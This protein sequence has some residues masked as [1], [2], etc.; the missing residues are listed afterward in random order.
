MR[1]FLASMAIVVAALLAA[2]TT[3]AHVLITDQT[4]ERGAILH[5]VPDDDPIA[6]KTAT[7]FF[8]TQHNLLD[9]TS[10]ATVSI[11]QEGS[12]QATQLATKIDGP[13]ITANFVF[14]RQGVYQLRYTI[15]SSAGSLVFEHTA[16]VS[17]GIAVGTLD[18][19]R[20]T[21]AEGV[22]FGCSALLA[23][24]GILAWNRRKD[25]ARQST[26]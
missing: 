7:L 8:D 1:Y 22:L 5:I 4:G 19:P 16:R 21:W 23:C 24:L 18:R 6:G 13:L 12:D 11:H 25:I 9:A 17:R 15:H 2:P 14:P 26:F 10:T 3:Q 20:H